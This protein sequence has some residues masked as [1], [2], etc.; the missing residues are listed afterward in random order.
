MSPDYH[1]SRGFQTRRFQEEIISDPTQ[2]DYVGW[3]A[4]NGYDHFEP[5]GARGDMYYTP[6]ISTLPAK[7]HP[8]Q[9]VGDES[10]KFIQETA[11]GKEPWFLYAGFIHPHPPFAPPKP[12]HKLYRTPDMPLPFVPENCEQLYTWINRLQNRYKY[13]DRG[14]DQNLMRLIKA[15]YYA[16]ISFVDYQVGRIMQSLEQ[17]GQ[18][19]NTLIVYSSDHGEHLG[20]FNCFGKRSMQDASA[21]V[22]MVVRYPERFKP[23]QRCSKA[24][25]LVDL[26]PTFLEAAGIETRELGLDGVDLATVANGSSQRETVYSQFSMKGQAIYMAVSEQRKYVYSAGDGCEFFFDRKQDPREVSNLAN[27]PAAQKEKAECK[28]DLLRFLKRSREAAA[29]DETPAGLDWKQYPHIDETYL[30]DPDARLIFQDDVNPP[31][32]ATG[33]RLVRPSTKDSIISSLYDYD[34]TID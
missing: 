14:I 34:G 31:H 25:S 7:A 19:D 23:R 22:P 20:D 29:Y 3:L 27:Q 30:Q 18:L 8:T 24:V 13:R 2:D 1:A 21:K 28:G 16:T 6:Q 17:T 4:E 5:H 10:R 33:I 32:P 9:W 26:A 12:W 15:Y 11:S